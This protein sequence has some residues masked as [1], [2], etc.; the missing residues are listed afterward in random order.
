[1]VSRRRFLFAPLCLLPLP[2]LAATAATAELVES[3]GP[4]WERVN[5]SWLLWNKCTKQFASDD[6]WWRAW[7]SRAKFSLNKGN[8][9]WMT[10]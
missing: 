8:L 4:G 3:C 10:S 9:K 1:M 2:V 5:G 6:E 7:A